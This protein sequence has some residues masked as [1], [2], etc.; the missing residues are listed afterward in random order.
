MALL[1]LS[2]FFE[3]P[4]YTYE[5]SPMA[6]DTFSFLDKSIFNARAMFERDESSAVNKIILL[7]DTEQKAEFQKTGE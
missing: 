7:Y 5:L 6:K 1:L 3:N 2:Y 4:V